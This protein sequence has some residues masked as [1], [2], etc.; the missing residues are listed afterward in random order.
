[1]KAFYS[2]CAA[3]LALGTAQA[4]QY[5]YSYTPSI[6]EA[7][8]YLKFMSPRC[9]ALHDSIRTGPARGL[10]SQTLATARKDYSRD[11]REDESEAQQQLSREQQDKRSQLLAQKQGEARAIERT[12]QQE[13][14]CGEAKRILK[15]KKARTDLNDGEKADLKRFEDNYLALCT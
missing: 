14:Q 8:P 13:Q 9:A 1:M 7:P 11:C 5:R 4:Q 6:G 10:S 2:L 12:R 15:N 3:M